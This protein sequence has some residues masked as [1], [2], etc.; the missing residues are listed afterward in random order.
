MIPRPRSD[1]NVAPLADL[2]GLRTSLL[3][4]V[5]TADSAGLDAD[6]MAALLAAAQRDFHE[7]RAAT[8]APR[9]ASLPGA[10][11]QTA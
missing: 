6:D 11:E 1:K 5:R 3:G 10:G 4:W 8:G 9:G 2:T 7:R